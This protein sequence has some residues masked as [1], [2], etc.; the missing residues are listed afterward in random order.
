MNLY[1]GQSKVALRPKTTK[2]VSQ[3]RCYA[4]RL[5]HEIIAHLG[6]SNCLQTHCV[7]CNVM[8]VS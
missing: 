8:P 6:K 3:V 4:Y 7:L 5:C 1:E 2:Q